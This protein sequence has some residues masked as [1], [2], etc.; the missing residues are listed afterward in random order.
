[1]LKYKRVKSLSELPKDSHWA[2][3]MEDTVYVDSGY[4]EDKGS[5]VVVFEYLVFSNDEDLQT[6]VLEQET[7]KRYGVTK[8]YRVI[9]VTPAVVEKSIAIAIK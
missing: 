7:P 9:K 3:L 6:W 2:V 8:T 4:P 1:M 5:P